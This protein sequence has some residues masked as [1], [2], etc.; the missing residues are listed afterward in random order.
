MIIFSFTGE[1]T[2]LN[3]KLNQFCKRN[4]I[5]VESYSVERYAENEIQTRF[6]DYELVEGSLSLSIACHIGPG[7]MAITCM[8][9]V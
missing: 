7:A 2:Q 3:R 1:G 8:K 9:R 6:P 4:E 5:P